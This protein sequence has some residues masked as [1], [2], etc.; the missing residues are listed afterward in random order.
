M[1]K[2]ISQK[3]GSLRDKNVCTHTASHI[4]HSYRILNFIWILD[5]E[6]GA[7]FLQEIKPN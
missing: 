2:P 7:D 1:S 6:L 3:V 5:V 4:F